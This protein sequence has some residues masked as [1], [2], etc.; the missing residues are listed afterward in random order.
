MDAI[1]QSPS[2]AEGQIK[3][4]L[5]D[6]KNVNHAVRIRAVKRF[7]EYI[8]SYYPDIYDDD[9][10]LMFC[11]ALNEEGV[12]MGLLYYSGLDSGQYIHYIH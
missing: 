2:Y 5:N 10:D 1:R 9:V 6:L 8:A 4:L 7:Q 12:G 3:L 11:G